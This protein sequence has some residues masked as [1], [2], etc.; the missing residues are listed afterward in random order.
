MISAA[1]IDQPW[2]KRGGKLDH[3]VIAF[4]DDFLA[5]ERNERRRFQRSVLPRLPAE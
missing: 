5:S 3:L 2:A 1:N 4:G